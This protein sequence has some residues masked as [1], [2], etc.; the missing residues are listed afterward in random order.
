M[1]LLSNSA[2]GILI[3][4]VVIGVFLIF[5][6]IKMNQ[7]ALAVLLLIGFII[8]FSLVGYEYLRSRKKGNG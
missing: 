2:K 5:Q 8:L 1:G 7:I 6:F 4:A 3:L